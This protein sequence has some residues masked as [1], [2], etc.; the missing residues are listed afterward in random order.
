MYA[1][2]GDASKKAAQ[3]KSNKKFEENKGEKRLFF[4][5]PIA[6]ETTIDPLFD[7]KGSL[8]QIKER[9]KLKNLQ[10]K[11]K[12]I[13]KEKQNEII[14]QSKFLEVSKSEFEA[15]IGTQDE[16]LLPVTDSKDDTASLTE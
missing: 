6:Y 10:N 16:N 2:A 11:N 7:K 8:K 1:E 4:I 14:T 12:S 13:K 15:T 9:K 5:H 3:N